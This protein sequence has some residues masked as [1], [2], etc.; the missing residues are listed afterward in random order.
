MMAVRPPGAGRPV[1][2]R[3]WWAR[4][5]DRVGV[6]RR[7]PAGRMIAKIG[8][9]K[10]DGIARALDGVVLSCATY[11]MTCPMPRPIS[12]TTY[13]SRKK[14]IVA[15]CRRKDPGPPGTTTSSGS[16]GPVER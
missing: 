4:T 15:R 3:C 7:Q 2:E 5:R 6:C 10:S 8:C 1:C 13:E 9:M 14:I 16:S 12:V 11:S